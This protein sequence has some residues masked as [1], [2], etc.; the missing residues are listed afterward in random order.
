MLLGTICKFVYLFADCI[1]FDLNGKSCNATASHTIYSHVQIWTLY[2]L[3]MQITSTTEGSVRKVA[4]LWTWPCGLT[5]RRLDV[6]REEFLS[7]NI[8]KPDV[9]IDTTEELCSNITIKLDERIGTG[10]HYLTRWL[11]VRIIFFIYVMPQTV[12]AWLPSHHK[13][14]K[15]H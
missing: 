11:N 12:K 7:K 2:Q 1:T 10:S 13:T 5:D 6:T 9:N 3:T 4:Q 8:A 15:A 14:R